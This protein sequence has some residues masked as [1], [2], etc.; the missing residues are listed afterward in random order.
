VVSS[1]MK[2]GLWM[3]SVRRAAAIEIR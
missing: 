1:V 2:Y 3:S